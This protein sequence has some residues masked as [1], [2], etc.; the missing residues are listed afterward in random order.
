MRQPFGGFGRA[1]TDAGIRSKAAIAR[2]ITIET[3]PRRQHARNGAPVETARVQLRHKAPYLMHLQLVKRVG[4]GELYQRFDIACV[5]NN[6]VGGKPA[7]MREMRE[8]V[9]QMLLGWRARLAMSGN[10]G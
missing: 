8:K 4:F 6:R 9:R 7:F 2:E 5:T 3:T 1:Y 10:H